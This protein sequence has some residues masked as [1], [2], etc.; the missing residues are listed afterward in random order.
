MSYLHFLETNQVLIMFFAS[1]YLEECPEKR[2]R[3]YFLTWLVDQ[4]ELWPRKHILLEEKIL[5]PYERLF[6]FV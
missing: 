3:H 1:Q 2:Q 6:Q 5:R 4:E